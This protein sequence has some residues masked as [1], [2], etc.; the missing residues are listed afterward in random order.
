V[1]DQHETILCLEYLAL[2]PDDYLHHTPFSPLLA[3]WLLIMEPPI[4]GRVIETAW[5]QLGQQGCRSDANKTD[6]MPAS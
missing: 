2:G 6:G 3:Q 1:Y 4:L 5:V